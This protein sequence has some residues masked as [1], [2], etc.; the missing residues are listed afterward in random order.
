MATLQITKLTNTI[1]KA[2]AYIKRDKE[3]DLEDN[4]EMSI[5]NAFNYA[6]SDKSEIYKT[7]STGINCTPATAAQV[8]KYFMDAA[9]ANKS[10]KPIL[11]KNGKEV[12]GWHI[13]QCFEESPEQ[14][15]PEKANAIGVEF[16][17]KFFS[18]FPCVVSTHNNTDHIHNHIMIGAWGI[19]GKK[20]HSCNTNYRM[21]RNENDRL[22]KENNLSVL[23]K[24]AEMKM[25]KFKDDKGVTHFYEPTD[26]KNAIRIG[27]VSNANSYLAQPA[28]Q[29]V[30]EEKISN[31][32]TVKEDIDSLLSNVSDYEDLINCMRNAG[33]TVR[34]KKSDETYYKYVSFK[35]PGM[36]KAVRDK[37]IGE[38]YTRENLIKKIEELK[39][40]KEEYA[41]EVF[42]DQEE[43]A[44]LL[45][46]DIYVL[47]E[48]II[49]E[50]KRKN[51]E[52]R[53]EVDSLICNDLKIKNK[54]LKIYF[55]ENVKATRIPREQVPGLS[56]RN[57]YLYNCIKDDLKTLEIIEKNNIKAAPEIK[58]KADDLIEKRNQI[59][60]KVAN[61]RDVLEKYNK[62]IVVI[63]HYNKLKESPELSEIKTKELKM[64]TAA[65][66]KANLLDPESQKDYIDKYNTFTGNYEKIVSSIAAINEKLA[67]YNC[68][69]RTVDR[70][71]RE[72]ST[73]NIDNNNKKK[74]KER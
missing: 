58:N 31:R 36:E 71:T 35:A 17:R 66:D 64:Y 3:K 55:Y 74:E 4:K 33:Y 73:Q 47:D 5:D 21:M 50:K 59:E 61:I 68:C 16:A 27:E 14:L 40:K 25:V 44:P 51:G 23:E 12:L 49:N 63:E 30:K 8:S 7:V 2:F 67:E 72:Q 42:S 29:P 26:R 6:T 32:S 15:S 41:K 57:Q 56:K 65:L 34:D 19:D 70:I 38:E 18:K 46:D 13:K 62:N 60:S 10:I 37:S 9:K 1:G 52:D 45:P 43:V 69:I 53:E 20:Y 24:T 48:E 22:C 39:E 54:E 28:Y 11:S